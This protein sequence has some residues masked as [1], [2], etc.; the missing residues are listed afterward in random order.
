MRGVRARRAAARGA[1]A[2]SGLT[3]ALLATGC[4]TA[5]PGMVVEIV[6]AELPADAADHASKGRAQEPPARLIVAQGDLVDHRVS[7]EG[8]DSPLVGVDRPECREL[9]FAAAGFLPT[10]RTGWAKASVVA[11]PAPL[12][13]DATERQKRAAA[14]DAAS[15]TVTVVTLGSY[16]GNAAVRHFAEVRAA[17]EA[18][19]D[20]YSAT[21]GGETVK[22]TRVVPH[23]AHGGDEAVGYTVETE[24]DG[25]HHATELVVVRKGGTLANLVAGRTSGE[26]ELAAPVVEAQL[27]KLG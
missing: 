13:H 12:P 11:V 9:A 27:V 15:S 1:W 18:C 26:A 7:P 8:A 25:E 23:A 3:L 20:G 10:G 14:Q 6:P 2:V 22:V 16:A 19:T 24:Q 17:G 4:G 5:R 21:V